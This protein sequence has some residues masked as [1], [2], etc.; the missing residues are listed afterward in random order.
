[1]NSESEDFT[2]EL[3]KLIDKIQPSGYFDW[4]GGKLSTMVFSKL[5]R[6]STLY[7]FGDLSKGEE[8]SFSNRFMIGERKTI[9]GLFLEDFLT[10]ITAE[11]K[12]HY[13]KYVV[14]DISDGGKI[15]GSNIVKTYPLE[16]FEAAMEEQD[17]VATQGKII[18]I[19]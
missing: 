12:E 10:R 13:L 6:Y 19:S 4:I 9:T 2:S 18:L 16:E 14:D 1:M 3:E 11:E 7:I 8:M 5:P 15:F 17:K